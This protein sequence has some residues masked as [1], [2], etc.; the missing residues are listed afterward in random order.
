[1]SK[2]H[3]KDILDQ[4]HGL[5]RLADRLKW[6]I[7]YKEFGA[8][9]TEDSEK[10]AVSIRMLVGLHYLKFLENDNDENIL[11]RFCENPYW[12]Y[13]CGLETFSHKLPCYPDALLKIRKHFGKKKIK[14]ILTTL[15]N[16]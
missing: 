3:L 12:Q 15:I 11:E 14:Q 2:I 5:C 10:E 6:G 16:S 9:F 7:L 13:F 4:T 1:M 8:F